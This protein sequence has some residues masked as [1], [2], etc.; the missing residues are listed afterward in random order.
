LKY[1]KLLCVFLCFYS[2]LSADKTWSGNISSPG[3]T[4]LNEDLQI[5]GACT[6]TSNLSISALTT[7]V[8][9]TV[10][11]SDG[12][13]TGTNYIL[14]LITNSGQEITFDITSDYDLDFAGGTSGFF[15]IIQRGKGT[16]N[17]KINGGR[18]IT[19]RNG[20]T[21]EEG[22]DGVRYFISM[23]NATDGTVIQR[24]DN[25][26]EHAAFKILDNSLVTFIA[27]T[28][29][30]NSPTERGAFIFD[31]QNTNAVGRTYLEIGEDA[32]FIVSGHYV[33][34]LTDP[35]NVAVFLSMPAGLEP[36]VE[37]KAT[38][39]ASAFA[40]TLVINKNVNLPEL[41]VDPTRNSAYDG[42]QSGFILGTNSTLTLKNN[43][44]LDYVGTTTNI[45]PW[46][47][48]TTILGDRLPE[49]ILKARNAS[50]LFVDGAP[51]GTTGAL[52]SR[53]LMEGNSGIFFRSGADLNGSCTEQVDS[54]FSFTITPTAQP[55]REGNIIFD[56]EGALNVL[57]A[58]DGTNIINILSREVDPTGGLIEI[59]IGDAKFP[60]ITFAED[61]DGYLLQYAKGSMLVN[62]R[63]NFQNM[64][65]RHDDFFH[66]VNA[67]N[68]PQNSEPTYIGGETFK[69][70]TEGNLSRPK[71]ALYNS[72]VN[73]HTSAALT[74]VDLFITNTTLNQANQSYLRFYQNGRP[75]DKGTGR[76]LI[77]GTNPGSY[78]YDYASVVDGASYLDI[79][80]E[81]NQTAGY[82]H[83]LDLV[84]AVN[85]STVIY[86]IAGDISG[87]TSIQ[88][89]FLGNE[90]NIQIGSQ[91]A[92]SGV[93][94]TT[95]PKL[96]IDGNFFSFMSQ[97]GT[98]GQP[99]LSGTIGQG[100]MFVD[101]NGTISIAT[102]ARAH[103]S[104]MVTTSSSTAT[105]DLP[106]NRIN[107]GASTG[108]TKWNLNLATDQT[109]IAA[110][111]NV[112]DFTIDWKGTVKDYDGGFI[113]FDPVGSLG[114]GVV[115]ANLYH[116]PTIKGSVDELQIKRSR[117]GDPVHIMV[118]GGLV[119]ELVFLSGYD[120]SE[121]PTGLVAVKN[122]GR[123]A[124]GNNNT[125][126]D[127][128]DAAVVLGINGVMLVA[129]GNGVIDLNTDVEINNYCHIMAG[130]TFGQSE[131]QKLYINAKDSRILRVK[132]EGVLDLS[133][134]TSD[135]MR[136]AFSGEVKLIFEPGSQLL[137]GGGSIFF[138][139][140]AELHIQNEIESAPAAGTSVSSTDDFRVPFIGSGKITFDEDAVCYI[141]KD[142]YLSFEWQDL[143]SSIKSTDF[144]VSIQD[145]ASFQI[146]SES[147]FGGAV[148]IGNTTNTPS[149]TVSFTLELNGP[150]ALFEI[151][152]QGFFGVGVGIVDKHQE[153][154][155]GWL[156]GSLYNVNTFALNIVQGFMKHNTILP[157]SS[158]EAALFAIG[159]AAYS[160]NITD[161][162][163]FRALGGGNM[164]RIGSGVA[165]VHPT[166]LT[167]ASNST[168]LF[169]STDL[170]RDDNNT[171]NI[172][173][174]S[175]SG[176]PQN[177]FNVFKT[178]A[179]RSMSAPAANFARI[180]V[181][182]NQIG[183]VYNDT[184]CRKRWVR[185]LGPYGDR[186]PPDFSLRV[187][188]LY[189]NLSKN[190]RINNAIQIVR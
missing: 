13:V 71:I 4:V 15:Q 38:T 42:V 94:L 54:V 37:L 112:S 7:N 111:L 157:G 1:N 164:I 158:T 8:N 190:G 17:W 93:T 44:Y 189:I 61:A 122:D 138:T 154:P 57:G 145:N 55:A 108:I 56:V 176:I 169:S 181:G 88:T 115:A 168:G 167:T 45:N 179:V 101:I 66:E 80:Q 24:G 74:G 3:D 107:F 98:V 51:A 148:Q 14:E 67:T 91:S 142:A 174:L 172:T 116:L 130:P 151:N 86:G 33:A 140:Q 141:Q 50:A 127:S 39:N 104:M 92:T 81:V 105:I 10:I 131:V 64:I 182:N 83:Q 11:N 183:Y 79:Y 109:V 135:N 129:D 35:N 22:D 19:L 120:S 99:E 149:N 119:R 106:K 43:T 188:A 52:D 78:A 40:N 110:G 160:L 32:G 41:Y 12:S 170:V 5:N 133:T 186:V 27:P 87:Q 77:L 137:L 70:V 26:V 47:S 185:V 128:I 65:I 125:R 82:T 59:G 184:I 63:T 97:G 173:A 177:F 76:S 18:T 134:F 123:V 21:G 36:I 180:T 103:F 58:S 166:V 20:E 118:D 28:L 155:N 16:V 124:I 29:L 62:N 136:L 165:S 60:K 85:D 144:E 175:A 152:S 46:S 117:I 75:I 9:V 69:L 178:K 162:D 143:V 96:Y 23:E 121:A 73:L 72:S 95:L 126:K 25:T 30:A 102:T 187:G 48:P 161:F 150:D 156:V 53:I 84:T 49:E 31:T 147:F 68:T 171:V 2:F 114:Q 139:G 100:G 89:L 90:S 146:G 163:D 34:N 132:R 159:P 113:P 6:L 153:T